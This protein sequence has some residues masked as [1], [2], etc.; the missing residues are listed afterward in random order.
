M[1]IYLTRNLRIDADD[2]LNF[3]LERR[4]QRA[5]GKNAGE[6]Y[7]E[8]AGYYGNLEQALSAAVR[9][10]FVESGNVNCAELL[11]MLGRVED[12]L[13]EFARA[14]REGAPMPSAE[15]LFEAPR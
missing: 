6:V 11:A 12:R 9:K 3:A 4:R 13:K 10:S 14:V 2:G 8:T 7:W 1:I 5:E 15:S